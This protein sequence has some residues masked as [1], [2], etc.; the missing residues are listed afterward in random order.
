MKKSISL[1]VWI[2]VLLCLFPTPVR[3]Q[4]LDV[5]AWLDNLQTL[6]QRPEVTASSYVIMDAKS[7]QLLLA[8]QPHAKRNPASLTKML[9]ALIVVEHTV[10]LDQMVTVPDEATQV[11]PT[12]M[13]LRSGEQISVRNLLKGMLVSSANDAA[14]SLAIW[15][16]GSVPAFVQLMN[17]KAL[18]LGM[19]DTTFTNPVGFDEVGHVSSAYDIALVSWHIMQK[20]LLCEIVNTAEEDITGTAGRTIWHHIISTNKLLGTGGVVGIKTGMTQ[21]AGETLSLDIEQDDHEWIVVL[22][23]SQD[24]FGDG[25]ILRDWVVNRY[26]FQQ[27]KFALPVFSFKDHLIGRITGHKIVYLYQFF[28]PGAFTNLWRF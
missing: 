10:D 9:T 13:G 15:M 26:D 23:G 1:L 2:G 16:S 8:Q 19:A 22:L 4:D 12:K 17:Q 25:E 7:G 11:D 18:V 5:R 27:A 24:R 28:V 6:N 3:A 20:P 14:F 21:E